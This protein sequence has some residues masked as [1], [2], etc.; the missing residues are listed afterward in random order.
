MIGPLG[1]LG[2]AS[3]LRQQCPKMTQRGCTFPLQTAASSRLRVDHLVRGVGDPPCGRV[4][5]QQ[6]RTTHPMRLKHRQEE[7]ILRAALPGTDT[8]HLTRGLFC[9]NSGLPSHNAWVVMWLTTRCPFVQ[10]N[11]PIRSMTD[12]RDESFSLRSSSY[13]FIILDLAIVDIG[14]TEDEISTEFLHQL[15]SSTFR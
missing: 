3:T 11:P 7:A 15:T 9:A 2:A 8:M 6:R 1:R 14:C 10:I 5:R 13:D 4:R 12:G